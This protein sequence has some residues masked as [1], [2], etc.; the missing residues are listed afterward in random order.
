MDADEL[1]SDS[2]SE[3]TTGSSEGAG[4]GAEG[5]DDEFAELAAMMGPNDSQTGSDPDSDA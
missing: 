5:D 2:S 4:A 1:G 3:W